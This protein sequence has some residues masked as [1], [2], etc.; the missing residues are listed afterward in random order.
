MSVKAGK[1]LTFGNGVLVQRLQNVG[2]TSLNIPS[3]KISETGNEL[4]V[5][6]VFDIPDLSFTMNTLDVTIDPEALLT[7]VDATTLVNGDSITLD[8]NLPL[9]VASPIKEPGTSKT[10]K[11]GVAV[12]NL[13]LES[14]TYKFGVNTNSTQEYSLQGDSVY[15]IEG[16]PYYEEF[17]G[18]GAT[19]EFDFAHTALK[20]VEQGDNIYGLNVC[21]VASDGTYNRLVHGI[22]FTDDATGIVLDDASLAPVDSKVQVIYGSGDFG[23]FPQSIHATPS[24]KPAAVKGKDIN[25]LVATGATKLVSITTTNASATVVGSGFT[26]SDVGSAVSGTDIPAGSTVITFTDATHV[27]LSHAATGAQTSVATFQPPMVRWKG[28]Q[29]VEIDRKVTLNQ[30]SEL[31]NPHYVNVDYDVPDVSG[32]IV[33]RPNTMQYLF[34]QLAIITGTA[35]GDIANLLVQVP[36]KVWVQ[37]KHP[38]TGAI[39][40]TFEIGDARIQPPPM[41]AAVTQKL[42]MT[43]PFSS[44]SG[45]L[46]IYK[47]APS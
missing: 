43:M 24:V 12:P 31:G 20:T 30:D 37:V 33:M 6:T 42:E 44:D 1:F 36:L 10:S 4:T 38:D 41:N 25:L 16:T 46:V 35:A 40:K 28:V 47:G 21:I 7:G 11:Y 15:Y 17:N 8:D 19:T 3:E 27:V 14:A 9:H 34:A 13:I 26:A 32:N 45:E 5:A 29:S 18:D 23:T 2:P 39:L 22:D